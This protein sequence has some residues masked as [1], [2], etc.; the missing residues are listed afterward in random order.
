MTGRVPDGFPRGF[1]WGG[2][3]AACQAEGAWKEGGKGMSVADTAMHYSQNTPRSEYKKV[4]H[5]KIRAAMDDPGTEHY[6]KRRGIDF[7]HN[8][9]EDIALC[10]EMGFTA[11]RM[12]IAWSRIFPKGDESVP[13]EEGI[14]FYD[15][16]FDELEKYRIEPIVTLSHFEM[17]LHLALEYGGWT[18]RTL[19]EYFVRYCSVCFRHFG[20]RVRYWINFNEMNGT[21]FNTF[22][23]TGI[24]REDWGDQFEQ[25]TY[26]AAHHQFVASAIAVRELKKY[27]PEAMMGCMVVPFTRYPGTC[28]PEDVLK[29]H[30]DMH[31]DCYFYTDIHM[32]GEYP[33]YALRYFRDRQIE[34]E[35]EPEDFRLLKQYPAG[36]LAFS[37]YSTSISS[38]EL[39]GW[40]TT[41]GNLHAQL[42]NPHLDASAWGWQIDPLGLRYQLGCFC[43]RYNNPP[44]L[45]AENGLGAVDVVE[46]DGAIHD[47]Y[48]IEYLRRH[49]EQMREAVMDG[50]NVIGYTAWSAIDIVSSGTSEMAKRYGFIYVDLDD[51]NQGTLERRRKDSFYWYKKVIASNGTEL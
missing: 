29:M 11:F 16:V 18:N 39:E 19:I 2:A 37:Y 24:I 32:R 1:L 44:L 28:K 34:L 38:V 49:I 12:S 36:F 14:A 43:D 46:P 23:S 31:L 48:R 41:D 10:A 22:S 50:V 20:S 25:A 15:A 13:N 33:G 51:D 4:T 7:Y 3:T 17:P 21:R 30:Q 9:K 26:Q 5:D 6:P 40:E 45:V 27:N 35:T 42:K 8:Y 47:D